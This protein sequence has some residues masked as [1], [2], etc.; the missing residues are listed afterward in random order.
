MSNLSS[1]RPSWW[2][3][4]VHGSAWERARETFRRDWS[5]TKHDLGLGGH[6]MNQTISDTINQAAGKQHLPTINQ[7]NPPKVIADW[8]EAE[9]FYRYGHAARV[10]FGDEHPAWNEGL[11]LKLKSEWMSA[12]DKAGRDWTDLTRYVRRGYEQRPVTGTLPDGVP[13]ADT[14]PGARPSHP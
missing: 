1:W 4:Q 8:P 12:Q 9:V 7:T 10:Q 13:F 11:E 14:Q 6:E 5:Q 3:D 2:S